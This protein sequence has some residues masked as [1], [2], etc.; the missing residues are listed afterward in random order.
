LRCHE[1]QNKTPSINVILAI[2]YSTPAWSSASLSLATSNHQTYPSG[3]RSSIQSSTFFAMYSSTISSRHAVLIFSMSFCQTIWQRPMTGQICSWI[4][5]LWTF[6]CGQPNQQTSFPAFLAGQSSAIL[7]GEVVC[8]SIRPVL[9][10]LSVIS[11]RCERWA[12]SVGI[13][14]IRRWVY[15]S[16]QPARVQHPLS[17][18]F[19]LS[20]V[21]LA[22]AVSRLG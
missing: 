7:Q 22:G 19:R 11:L 6:Q 2:S 1:K 15:R 4:L 5:C 21:G 3:R 20:N 17:S 18:R 12:Q 13:L 16:P 14:Y 8:Q 10:A 9:L